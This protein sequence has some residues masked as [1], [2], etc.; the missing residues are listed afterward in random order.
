MLNIIRKKILNSRTKTLKE[1]FRHK[2]RLKYI[3]NLN[4]TLESY[5]KKNKNKIFYVIRRSPGGG[6]FSNLNYVLNHLLIADKMNFVP[7][8]DMENY[9]TFYNEKN[10]IN[11]SFNAWDYYFEKIN[12]YKLKEVYSSNAV[13]LTNKKTLGNKF[14]DGYENLNVEHRKIFKKYVK[15]KKPILKMTEKFIKENFKNYKILGVHFRGSDQKRQERHPFPATIS[16][17]QKKIENLNKKYI[18]DKIFFVTEEIKYLEYF[19]SKYGNKRIYIKGF[20]SNKI[21]IFDNIKRKN[22]RYK[23][24]IE[25]I[26]NMICLSKSNYLVGVSSNMTGASIFYG[27]KSIKFFKIDN[28]TNSK[29]IFIAQYLWYFKKILPSFLGGFKS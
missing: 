2:K 18:Y 7:I 27:N 25:S 23:L 8:I 21:N 22:H 5:G 11:N 29:N 12:R 17:I 16:Q 20:V 28:G 9:P 10:K 14:F 4:F 6:F 1:I 15:F 3:E 26:M 19:K 24:G 13:I